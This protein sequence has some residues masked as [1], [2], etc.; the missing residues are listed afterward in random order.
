MRVLLLNAN[1]NPAMTEHVVSVARAYAPDIAFTGATGRFGSPHIGTR[2]TYVIAAHAALD[3]YAAQSER[4]DAVILAC[5]GDPGLG[6]L[7]D[8]ANVPVFGLAE[9]ACRAA[10]LRRRPFSIVTG[11]A[12]W[13]PMLT[14]YLKALELTDYL[15]SV[16]AIDVT[17]SQILADP[18]GSLDKL[19]QSCR[20][21][22][23]QDGA[24]CVILGGAGLVGLAARMTNKVPVPLMDCLEPAIDAVRGMVP[25]A[26]SSR[27]T[28]GAAATA[29][30]GIQQALSD[31]LNADNAND[32]RGRRAGNER[33]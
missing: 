26:L 6:A 7:Q 29:F 4:F 18:E 33:Q 11:G 9:A 5:F 23:A 25:N 12:R 30:V 3:C 17:G 15:A 19:A 22:A 1:T 20:Q 2:A 21:A 28:A 8:L 13:V 14:D 27:P 32:S 31:L 10:A 16:R 24:T